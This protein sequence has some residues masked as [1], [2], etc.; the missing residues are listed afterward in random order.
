MEPDWRCRSWP[1]I[2]PA[3]HSASPW[4][5]RWQPPR[6]FGDASFP[7][8]EGSPARPA[9]SPCTCPGAGPGKASLS[10]LWYGCGP[11]HCPLDAIPTQG[12][13][14]SHQTI[15]GLPPTRANQASEGLLLT[16]VPQPGF[17]RA[18]PGHHW[19]C[20]SANEW[21]H[22]PSHPTNLSCKSPNHTLSVDMGLE[23]YNS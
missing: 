10:L 17:P 9:N 4:E 22:W 12:N 18:T 5:R 19:P 20:P 21:Y 11:F 14:F 6:P 8:L 13:R 1:T 16:V 3:G 2:W 7:W 23:S 15:E